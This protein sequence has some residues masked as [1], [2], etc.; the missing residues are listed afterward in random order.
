MT[1]T[2]RTTIRPDQPIEVDDTEYAQLKAD[3]LLFEDQ[4]P[5]V[6]SAAPAVPPKKTTSGVTGSK[7]S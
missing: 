2:V 7:E 1:R 4:T 5:E 3:G 6:P